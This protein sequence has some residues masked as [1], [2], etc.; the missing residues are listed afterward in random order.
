MKEQAQS[1]KILKV[2]STPSNNK[3]YLQRKE[4]NMK[5]TKSDITK[6]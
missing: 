1:T 2:K 3:K 6:P 4:I 5:N